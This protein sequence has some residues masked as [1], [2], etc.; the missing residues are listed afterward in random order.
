MHK[1]LRENIPGATLFQLAVELGWL[2]AAVIVAGKL[3]NPQWSPSD[4]TVAS[5][6]VFA[7]LIACFNFTFG[8]YRRAH[9]LPLG[10]YVLREFVVLCIQFPI[11]YIIAKVL[12]G[13][14]LFREGIG[15]AVLYALFGLIVV[16]QVIA[17]PV[18][19]ALLPWRVLVL[20]TGPEA[21]SIEAS[22]EVANLPRLELIGFF[23]LD[24]IHE[25]SVSA[26]RIVS[27]DASFEN[28]VKRLEA[29]EIIVAVREQRGDVLPLQALLDCRLRGVQVTDL[30]RFF[31]RVHGRVPIESL[32]ASWLIYGDGFRQSWL[33]RSI[34]RSFDL[35]VVV[36]LLILALPIMI[37]SALVILLST[38]TPLIYRQERVGYRG[39]T[40]TVLKFRSMA[41]NAETDGSAWGA[42][43]N[44]ARVTR[45]GRFIRRTRID[46]LPQLINVLKG[47]MSLIGPRPERPAFV[48]TLTEKIPFYA[49]RH[50]VPPGITGWAQVRYSYGGT[51]EEESVKKLE[52]DLY[53]VKNNNL[54]LDLLILLRTVRVVLLSEGAR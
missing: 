31:E 19:R 34:K 35:V 54:F 17:W 44:D 28:T 21:R 40:F 36:G 29:D 11:A 37:I 7:T 6:F 39:Q 10:E 22:L 50:S 41:K 16:R 52:Y 3:A 5:A 13:G 24:R 8:F 33:R 2:F 30:A 32:K 49:V 1:L 46:E 42:A 14:S 27:K 26:D 12:L 20:G 38:G 48:A 9:R 25:V 47:E 18:V 45:F 43:I 23:G 15:F 53:Y 51:V 4:R